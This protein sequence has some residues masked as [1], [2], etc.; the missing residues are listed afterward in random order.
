VTTPSTPVAADSTDP[1]VRPAPPT[2]PVLFAYDGSELAG[3]AI[4]RVAQHLVTPREA[5]VVCV[6]QPADVGFQPITPRHFDADEALA[7][8]QA[9]AEAAE[10][11]AE[12]ARKVGFQA[13]S[14]AIEGAPTWKGILMAAEQEHAALIVIG[15]QE[16]HGLMAHLLGSV[17]AAVVAHS[18]TS[19]LVVRPPA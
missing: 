2:G 7:V 14:L 3:L 8:Q 10:F 13:R 4:E 18:A 9:A 6:W 12:L 16:R 5:V 1:S 19:V 11:G 15:S 17:A